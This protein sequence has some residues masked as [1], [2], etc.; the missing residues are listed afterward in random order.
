MLDQLNGEWVTFQQCLIDSD[1]MLKKCKDKFKTGL[2]NSAEDFK[3]TVSNLLEEFQIKG[4]FGS[5]ISV[6]EVRSRISWL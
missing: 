3:K 2:I 1:V 5:S 4:P 6:K